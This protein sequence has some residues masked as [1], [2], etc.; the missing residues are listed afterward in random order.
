MQH[1]MQ[2]RHEFKKEQGEIYEKDWRL[3]RRW[4]IMEL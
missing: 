3:G 1:F 2:K 4:K